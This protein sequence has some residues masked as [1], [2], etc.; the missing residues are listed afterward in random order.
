MKTIICIVAVLFLFS[1]TV[2]KTTTTTENGITKIT[3]K[4]GKVYQSYLIVKH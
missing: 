3:I 2:S 1:C 4:K